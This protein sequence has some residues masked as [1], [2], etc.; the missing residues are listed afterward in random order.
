MVS[1]QASVSSAA[2]MVGMLLGMF[3]F[4]ILLIGWRTRI[5]MPHRA[6]SQ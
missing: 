2:A 1:K 3:L 6:K 5:G 4:V